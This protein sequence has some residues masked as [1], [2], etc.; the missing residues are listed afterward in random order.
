MDKNFLNK[1]VDQ[2]LRRNKDIEEESNNFS[3]YTTL[4]KN[5]QCA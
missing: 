4:S 2:I 3:A 1:V 5:I